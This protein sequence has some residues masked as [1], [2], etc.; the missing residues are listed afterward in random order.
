VSSPSKFVCAECGG[1]LYIGQPIA[2]H[3][4]DYHAH[5]GCSVLAGIEAK[6]GSEALR[7]QET[8]PPLLTPN[9]A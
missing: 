7:R 4:R 3:G 6:Y 1:A 5:V 2:R 9:A 8:L